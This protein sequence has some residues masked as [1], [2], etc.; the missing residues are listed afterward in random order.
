MI[1]NSEILLKK[2]GKR[3]W[4][5]SRDLARVLRVDDAEFDALIA[6]LQALQVQ[7]QIVRVPGRGW[8][9]AER[10]PYRVGALKVSRRGHAFVSPVRPDAEGDFFVPSDSVGGAFDGDLVLVELENPRRSSRG[11]RHEARN[12]DDSR[13]RRAQLVDVVR[14]RKAPVLGRFWR[15]DSDTGKKDR[16]G[17]VEPIH[18]NPAAEIFIPLGKS[19]DA[20]NGAKVLVRL[21][22]GWKHGVYARGEVLHTV[23]DEGTYQS[24]LDL[25]ISEYGLPQGFSDAEITAADALFAPDDSRASDMT[26][27]REDLR[28]LVTLTIDPDD[29]KDFDDAISLERL[30]QG[31]RRL[32]VHIAD[33]AAY[34]PPGSLLDQTARDRG[35]SVYLPGHVV[36]ML[37]ERISNNLA[38]LRPDED[39]FAKTVFIDFDRDGQVLASRITRS[40]IRSHRRFT[41]DEALAILEG[42]K[43]AEEIADLPTDADEFRAVLSDMGRLRDALHLRRVERGCLEMDVP[44]VCL[45]VAPG[46]EVLGAVQESR[47]AAH[48]LI[49][50]FMLA[51]NE[52]VARFMQKHDLPHLARTHANPADDRLDEFFTVLATMD[53]RFRFKNKR[54]SL[55]KIIEMVANEPYGGHVQLQLLRSLPHALYSAEPGRHF[56]LATDT[57]CHFTSPIRR[58]PDLLVHQVLDR[59]LV[60]QPARPSFETWQTD[61]P[62]LQWQTSELEQRAEKAEREL[63]RLLLIRHLQEHVGKEMVGTLVSLHNF[64]FFV[65]V[66]EYLVD[67]FVHISSLD[68]DFYEFDEATYCLVGRRRQNRLRLGSQVRLVLAELNPDLRD[69]RF[70]YLGVS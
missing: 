53:N 54:P 17:F 51:A 1:P 27:G 64:G 34:V 29:A 21:L 18:K 25:I 11:R 3:D 7:G 44:S 12:R 19:G 41:Y 32:G 37:P 68:D 56:A 22:D 42:E 40:I 13:L 60:S 52:A 8:N 5:K 46:G 48:H 49:E 47:D 26:E 30:S 59:F 31:R 24:D 50:E 45:Q 39:R 6:A 69:I 14:R 9:L 2:I 10:V 67:G 4:I 55:Q 15:A 33:V 57:Y 38:S 28:D 62:G 63:S 16:D 70:E 23:T 66:E 61:M 65:F 20:K 36:P 35:T 58:Y 43:H